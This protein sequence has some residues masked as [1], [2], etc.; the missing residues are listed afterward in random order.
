MNVMKSIKIS[1]C[2]GLRPYLDLASTTHTQFRVVF[3]RL[4]NQYLG[5]GLCTQ[6]VWRFGYLTLFMY[7]LYEN[8]W[9]KL[10]LNGIT[11]KMINE[12]DSLDCLAFATI[13]VVL[14]LEIGRL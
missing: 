3:M 2:V 14:E 10:K 4:T 9:S 5:C 8:L 12:H 7:N 1:L 6:V 11:D 13:F